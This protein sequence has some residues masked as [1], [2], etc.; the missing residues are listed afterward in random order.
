M[1][2]EGGGSRRDKTSLSQD[3]RLHV[4]ELQTGVVARHLTWDGGGKRE[5]KKPRDEGVEEEGYCNLT[6][7]QQQSGSTLC[8]ADAIILTM[9]TL[10]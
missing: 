9:L 5:E 8:H 3:A 10:K 1:P 6:F 7:P 2:D 4:V